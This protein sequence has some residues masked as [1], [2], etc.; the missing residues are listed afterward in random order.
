MTQDSTLY[1]APVPKKLSMRQGEFNPIGKKYVQLV[2]DEPQCLMP[3]VKQAGLDL[4]ISASPL[5][6]KDLVG[7]RFI[8]DE[9][10]GMP[11]DG[12]KLVIKPDVIEITSSTPAG[13]F[14]GACTLKQIARQSG[15]KLP[16]LVISDWPDLAQRGVMLDIS[17]DKVPT[18]ETL[19]H[20][21]DLLAEWKINEFQLYTEHTFAYLAHPIVWEHASPMTGEQI[22]QLD[23]YCR[24]RF[25]ELVPNQNSFG[26]LRR[27][28]THDKYRPMAELPH[29]GNTDWGYM[30]EPYSISPASKKSLP[31]LA[32]LYDELLPHFTSCSFNVGCDETVDLGFGRSKKL[33]KERGS[34]RVYLDFLME[35]YKLV[36]ERGR[37][38]QF[39]GDII[40]RHPELIPELP[41][42]IVALEWG[43]EAKHPFAEN[44]AKFADS[45]IPF[46]VCP[47]TSAW[48]TLTGRTDN[49][50]GN[51]ANAAK[52][53]FDNGAV[54][55]LNTSWGDNGHWNP[56]SVEYLGF[57]AGAMASWNSKPDMKKTIAQNLSLHAFEDMTLKS[58]KAFYDLGNAYLIFKKRAFNCAIPWIAIFRDKENDPLLKNIKSEEFDEMEDFL[59]D[60]EKN[61]SGEKM[62]SSDAGIVRQELQFLFDI[63]HLSVKGGKVRLGGPKP[64]GF[65]AEGA[66]IKDEHRKV[67]LLRNRPG[68]LEDSIKNIKV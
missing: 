8:I 23:A 58:G 56:N 21:V 6:P 10:S 7:L 14:Y 11:V 24:E 54:G 53:G 5:T 59:K 15:K 60:I 50:I 42:D 26:H 1:L 27:W 18:M 4:E 47:G 29:G 67:W 46:Y 17:R 64:S 13:S 2:T 51:I 66:Q 31:F 12:Y 30:D 20:L 65:D 36:T 48:S 39:W 16:C 19:Y 44:S 45:G 49:A 28:L 40:I 35:I 37:T 43:Y 33:C 3:A 61:L 34:D 55:M 63:M 52:N 62:T 9:T 68:G 25:I 57:M 32:G 41:K 22:L 38:M